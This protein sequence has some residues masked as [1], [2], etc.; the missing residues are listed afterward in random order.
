MKEWIII[1]STVVSYLF[2]TAWFVFSV[3]WPSVYDCWHYGIRAFLEV[4]A[5]CVYSWVLV[6]YGSN[7]IERLWRR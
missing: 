7:A 3:F 5:I 6:R 2:F 4:N 1:I